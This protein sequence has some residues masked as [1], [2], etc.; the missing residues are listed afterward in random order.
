[1]GISTPDCTCIPDTFL[2]TKPNVLPSN[3]NFQLNKLIYYFGFYFWCLSFQ[4]YT[5]TKIISKWMVLF[6]HLTSFH[7]PA[8][9]STERYD[10]TRNVVVDIT[11]WKIANIQL[12]KEGLFSNSTEKTVIVF[13][14]AVCWTLCLGFIGLAHRY[15]NKP[16]RYIRY[17]QFCHC[18]LGTYIVHFFFQGIQQI[19]LGNSLFEAVLIFI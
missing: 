2:T 15:L 13:Y 11:S 17:L 12:W 19:T 4:K 9:W 14:C 18:V 5:S 7:L 16:G 8:K 6:G 10:L 1:M 3:F